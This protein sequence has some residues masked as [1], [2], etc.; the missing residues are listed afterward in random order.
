[1]LHTTTGVSTAGLVDVAATGAGAGPAAPGGPAT[2]REGRRAGA[3]GSVSING[4]VE[5]LGHAG[6]ASSGGGAG[7]AGGGAGGSG[8]NNSLGR[9]MGAPSPAPPTATGA[10]S[11]RPGGR[12]SGGGSVARTPSG[13]AV[14]AGGAAGGGGGAVATRPNTAMS[15]A[16]VKQGSTDAGGKTVGGGSAGGGGGG[17]ARAGRKGADSGKGAAPPPP[18]PPG[19]VATM[20]DLGDALTRFFQES[21]ELAPKAPPK[22]PPSSSSSDGNDGAA[23]SD[24][25]ITKEELDVLERLYLVMPHLESPGKGDVTLTSYGPLGPGGMSAATPRFAASTNGASRPISAMPPSAAAAAAGLASGPGSSGAQAVRVP[26]PAS[27]AAAAAAQLNSLLPQGGARSPSP[28]MRG[29]TPSGAMRSVGGGT[30]AGDKAGAGGTGSSPKKSRS[31]GAAPSGGGGAAYLPSKTVLSFH[32]KALGITVPL[33]AAMPVPTSGPGLSGGVPG[34]AGPFGARST[35]D[36]APLTSAYVHRDAD[37]LMM[38]QMVAAAVAAGQ[39]R[40]A[41]APAA[42]GSGA[43][44]ARQAA[45]SSAR[46]QPP[47]PAAKR[48][49]MPGGKGAAAAGKGGKGAAAAGGKGGKKPPLPP[50]MPARPAVPVHL[51]HLVR[52]GSAAVGALIGR[53]QPAGIDPAIINAVVS[54][55]PVDPVAGFGDGWAEGGTV[56]APMPSAGPLAQ[57]PMSP[58][59]LP[60][61]RPSTSAAGAGGGGSKPGSPQRHGSSPG[62]GT[63]SSPSTP[64]P[65]SSGAGAN[66]GGGGS[67]PGTAPVGTASWA[68][69]QLERLRDVAATRAA[70]RTAMSPLRASLAGPISGLQSPRVAKSLTEKEMD[71]LNRSMDSALQPLSRAAARLGTYGES[72]PTAQLFSNVTSAAVPK[73]PGSAGLGGGGGG[74]MTAWGPPASLASTGA[75]PSLN[76]IINGGSSR[77]G[78]AA[79]PG[80]SPGAGGGGGGIGLGVGLFGSPIVSRPAAAVA[81]AVLAPTSAIPTPQL[82]TGPPPAPIPGTAA[83]VTGMPGGEETGPRRKLRRQDYGQ[84]EWPPGQGQSAPYN[85]LYNVQD[86]MATALE[87][88]EAA[89]SSHTGPCDR[90]GEVGRLLRRYRKQ[91]CPP[92]FNLNHAINGVD[93]VVALV[94]VLA[95]P[96]LA[97]LSELLLAG[98]SL[99]DDAFGPLS[100]RLGSPACAALRSLDLG[101]NGLSA[102]ALPPLLPLLRDELAA[103]SKAQRIRRGLDAKPPHG[104]LTRLVMDANPI[105]DAGAELICDAAASDY[106]A[107]AEL[108]LS[109]C[110][111]GERG[112]AACGRLMENSSAIRILDLSWN[113]LGRRGGQALGEGLRAANSIQQLY[114]QW[115]GITDLGA[116]H[117]AKALK[118]NASLVLLDMSGDSVSGDTSLV[119]LDSLTDNACLRE[120]ILR[121]NPVGVMA[122]R[123]LLKAMHQGVLETVDLLG[124]S[125]SMG[126]SSVVWD[127]HDPDGVYDLDLE[128]PAHYQV[129]VELVGLAALMGLRSWRNS[130]L[131]GKPF[132]LMSN[133]KLQIPLRGRL[134]VEFASCTP[135]LR[136]EGPLTDGEVRSMWFT[137]VDPDAERTPAGPM[138]VSMY[139]GQLPPEALALGSAPPSGL[140]PTLSGEAALGGAAAAGRAGGKGAAAATPS[141]TTSGGAARGP[142]SGAAGAAA[143]ATTAAAAGAGGG[144]ATA[145]GSGAAAAKGAAATAA[146]AGAGGKKPGAGGAAGGKGGGKGA[147]GGGKGGKG[148]GAGRGDM[149][150]TELKGATDEWKLSLLEAMVTDVY[151]TCGQLKHMI[152]CFD[153]SQ[154]KADAVV[155]AF[156]VLADTENFY[157]VLEELDPVIK[158]QVEVRLGKVRLFFPENPTG[159]YTLMLGQ[160]PHQ[161]VARQL[162]QQYT[163]Q[164]DAGLTNFPHSVCFTTCNMDGVPTDVSDPRKLYLPQ[165]GVLDLCFVDLRRV[166][167][168]VKPLSRPQFATLVAHLTNMEELDPVA[169]A[170]I[171]DHPALPTAVAALRR[172]EAWTRRHPVSACVPHLRA[173]VHAVR[174]REDPDGVT[175]ALAA[176]AAAEAAATTA[177]AAAAAA[178]SAAAAGVSPD[179]VPAAPPPAA[180]G[181]ST[182]G[183]SRF[184]PGGAAAD[185]PVR[186]SV[187][188]EPA[189]ANHRVSMFGDE[190]PRRVGLPPGDGAAPN[191]AVGTTAAA[192]AQNS[193][194][195]SPGTAGAGMPA[196][197]ASATDAGPGAG[198]SGAGGGGG[199]GGNSP[200]RSRSGARRGSVAGGAGVQQQ[201]LPL[202][203]RDMER[204]CETIRVLSVRHYLTC[205]Q[206]MQLVA[207]LPP[208]ATDE[209]VETVTTFWARTVDREAHWMDVMRSL[210]NDQQVRVCQRLGYKNVFKP[211][212]PA[213]HYRLRMFR[214]DER[215][216]AFEL[217]NKTYD[218]SVSSV[219]LFRNLTIDGMPRRVN[220]GPTMWTVLKGNAPD[221]ATPT[222][223]LEFDFW[224]PDE[225]AAAAMAARTIQRAFRLW[226]DPKSCGMP[227]RPIAEEKRPGASAAAPNFAGFNKKSRGAAP[228]KMNT[229]RKGGTDKKGRK[230]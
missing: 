134:H 133:S 166:P 60:G 215:Q 137:L 153:G 144:G 12:P 92:T 150:T 172:W 65:L 132:R 121:D 218:T 3:V 82:V 115:T 31:A 2:A 54:G 189:A 116:S 64:R 15:T 171:I 192:A 91:G 109:R 28:G 80:L 210:T 211:D 118:G 32:Q 20:T 181:T 39:S 10:L 193:V 224:W 160:L 30:A 175:N 79:Q 85:V 17:A 199:G 36:D 81:A 108:R 25:E 113:T 119:L 221:T 145:A 146:A 83:A 22:P 112:A 178:A 176:I 123:K 58:L 185:M 47:P 167:P 105:G 155:Q 163:Q 94:D 55:V 107:L 7:A 201:L 89:E 68:T 147:G 140:A 131:N 100:A 86:E 162:L 69:N 77:P 26:T 71:I 9:M 200:P 202:H 229:P 213:M 21:L 95:H 130:T 29:A 183:P 220:Q 169:L 45:G 74:A 170:R 157:A 114:L 18:P 122:A 148:A 38:R 194:S 24:D 191:K 184:G 228:S 61:T 198:G 104:V 110:G 197:E 96:D 142:N 13:R 88:M 124:C 98:N 139:D 101:L 106:T 230:T 205:W 168:G 52:P 49:N 174:W 138:F 182:A 158:A 66:G 125:F 93:Q 37:Y 217:Y 136:D 117:L 127:P 57:R 207:L 165:E 143:A 102:G 70:A 141:G 84:W 179:G 149:S 152:R 128:V 225:N 126:G 161:C 204:Y 40:P 76:D 35:P 8:S 27:A 154:C 11:P 90:V 56:S 48:A 190:T 51:Q 4:H 78:T 135:L 34:A 53:H 46:S 186:A 219:N 214:D 72:F 1:M 73:T 63:S 151:L 99:G 120:L 111:L 196:A 75:L 177:A 16:S 6:A 42:A 195:F 206:L 222:T 23:S 67:R 188:G 203:V 212:R 223:T 187:A 156:G 129:A 41:T 33:G 173:A 159:R 50:T 5:V 97:E 87:G 164:Y 43:A 208:A 227:S 14:L 44:A 180:P 62:M 59:R 226:R 209:R 103:M 19:K 216:V